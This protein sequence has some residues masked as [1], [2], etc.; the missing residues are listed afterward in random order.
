MQRPTW[1]INP[2]PHHNHNHRL[3]VAWYWMC[4]IS[5]VLCGAPVSSIQKL[6][7]VQKYATRMVLQ[8][9][10]RSHAKP[11]MRQ[12]HRMPVQDRIDYKVS[13]LTYKTL[14]TESFTADSRQGIPGDLLPVA[15][16]HAILSFFPGEQKEVFWS[17]GV[18]FGPGGEAS[19]KPMTFH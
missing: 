11:L 14:N 3:V 16:R 6:Q 12:L 2:N 5:A 8:A 9:P 18:R 17:S 7:R 19:Q 4:G 15:G 13:V 10:R 1:T